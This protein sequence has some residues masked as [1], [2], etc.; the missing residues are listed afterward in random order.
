MTPSHDPTNGPAAYDIAADTRRNLRRAV[1]LE[2]R[3]WPAPAARPHRARH[4]GPKRTVRIAG[5]IAGFHEPLRLLVFPHS[6][7]GPD[8]TPRRQK[9]MMNDQYKSFP[10]PCGFP[11]SDREHT[12]AGADP[13][14]GSAQVHHGDER[15]RGQGGTHAT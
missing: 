8:G 1:A 5:G 11:L 10:A 9:G 2:F 3:R 13:I 4:V 6:G 14:V 12:A 7:E 15:C